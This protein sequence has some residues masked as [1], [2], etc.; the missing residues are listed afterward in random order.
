MYMYTYIH[1]ICAAL[2]WRNHCL[3]HRLKKTGCTANSNSKFN[4]ILRKCPTLYGD[5]EIDGAHTA[6][7]VLAVLVFLG[8]S[9]GRLLSLLLT[10]TLAPQA[11]ATVDAGDVEDG[12]ALQA[13]TVGK[14]QGAP[15][16]L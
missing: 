14:I 11:R 15:V 4:A 12:D 2:I 16:N 5:R 3:S 8:A 13:R 6:R 7:R 9:L 1:C 10:G